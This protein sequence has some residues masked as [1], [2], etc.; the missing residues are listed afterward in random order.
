MV[1]TGYSGWE[2]ILFLDCRIVDPIKRLLICLVEKKEV[3]MRLELQ[4]VVFALSLA[5][6]IVVAP[7]VRAAEKPTVTLG[8]V[9]YLSEFWPAILAQK[10]GYFDE[11]GIK[12]DIVMTHASSKSVQLA[13]IGAV[14][15]GAGGA[16]DPIRAIGSGATVKLVASGA[17]NS[18]TM[19]FAKP[20]IKSIEGL[21]G[22]RVIV[23]GPE[24]IT[25]VWWAAMAKKHNMDPTKDVQLLYAG[26]TTDRF[27]ALVAGGVDA[28]SLSTPAA[29]AAEAKGYTNLGLFA[30]YTPN[31]PYI[32]YYA[33]EK[34][35]KANRPALVAFVKGLQK[36]TA[37]IYDRRNRDKAA[38]ILVET[39]KVDKTIALQTYDLIVQIKAFAPDASFT[40]A[41]IN[42]V[43]NT[44]IAAKNMT[45]PA[46]PVTAFYDGSYVKEA[47]G[48]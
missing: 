4:R 34:W 40:D 31:L 36:A 17:I 2:N 13:T 22:K 44:L 45:P 38:D 19:L 15:I 8:L 16:I 28:A 30:P 48:R 6:G 20:E 21:H 24:D 41:E 7:A 14:D 23:G 35:A 29:F 5:V 26:A 32:G 18:T 27:A 33:N 10:L 37:F 12:V 3:A 25:S 39:T 46:K 43:Q 11:A 1:G 9:A 42:A 47:A